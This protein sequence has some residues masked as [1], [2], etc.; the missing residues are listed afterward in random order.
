MDEERLSFI[1]LRI[2][3]ASSFE[4]VERLKV[5]SV[6][7]LDVAEASA[8]FS[9]SDPE[10][11]L[12]RTLERLERGAP[13]PV[14]SRRGLV[15]SSSLDIV[16]RVRVGGGIVG[17][18]SFFLDKKPFAKRPAPGLRMSLL[19]TGPEG[20]GLDSCSSSTPDGILGIGGGS[21]TEPEVSSGVLSNCFGVA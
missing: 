19:G 13:F 21:M 10:P 18:P 20:R 12:L 3:A 2:L 9:M 7:E 16:P 1:A 4:V 6:S 11:P 8:S 15:L 17:E 5:F 14:I